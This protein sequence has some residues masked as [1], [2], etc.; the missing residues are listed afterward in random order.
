MS[1]ADFNRKPQ[2]ITK[3]RDDI[4]V[5]VTNTCVNK[6]N[7]QYAARERGHQPPYFDLTRPPNNIQPDITPQ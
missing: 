6:Y 4:Y 5:Y 7:V 2:K 3:L 1:F